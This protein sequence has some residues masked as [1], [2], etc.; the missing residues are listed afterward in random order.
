MIVNSTNLQYL[1]QQFMVVNSLIK[2]YSK[3]KIM[4]KTSINSIRKYSW[5]N[6]K[7]NNQKNLI[8]KLL[9]MYKEPTHYHYIELKVNIKII[10][11]I[12][13]IILLENPKYSQP[14]SFQLNL[15]TLII[16]L[17]LKPL[18]KYCHFIKKYIQPMLKTII[19]I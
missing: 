9:H 17:N 10:N 19:K 5:I 3:S 8:L 7:F 16:I 14:Q 1:K 15:L 12:N 18:K 11:L 6:I 4:Q 2:K 13:V